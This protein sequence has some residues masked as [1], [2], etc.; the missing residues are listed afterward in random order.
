MPQATPGRARRGPGGVRQSGSRAMD[1]PRRTI[2]R[3]GK[4]GGRA[5]GDHRP[6]SPF[7]LS[8]ESTFCWLW[9]ACWIIAVEAWL[10]ICALA[11]A[12]V[13]AE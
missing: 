8:S 4:K 6:G 3:V 1:T 11:M 5:G 13:S 12:V 2:V 10:R 7:Y 9:F